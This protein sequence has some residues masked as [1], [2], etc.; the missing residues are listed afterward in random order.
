MDLGIGAKKLI[1]TLNHTDRQGNSKVIPKCTLPLTASNCV[2]MCITE[3]AVFEYINGVL[4]LTEIMPGSTLE[5]VRGKT[6]AKFVE[7]L[8]C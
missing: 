3:L 8:K 4:T 6:E 7:K 5:E 2:N 1:I